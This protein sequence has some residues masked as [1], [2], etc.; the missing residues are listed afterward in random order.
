VWSGNRDTTGI[1]S[2][3]DYLTIRYSETNTCY[4]F[5]QGIF[6]NLIINGVIQWAG[7][8]PPYLA[9]L[10]YDC[11]VISFI[12]GN[13]AST[14]LHHTS[15]YEWFPYGT[16]RNRWK[17]RF[18]LRARAVRSR[19]VWPQAALISLQSTGALGKRPRRKLLIVPK[20]PLCQMWNVA[21]NTFVFF[22]FSSWAWA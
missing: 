14:V 13:W 17:V 19:A 1:R 8:N 9:Y 5:L 15:I 2:C 20:W 18:I 22:S 10:K 21:L 6:H 4:S 3:T 7:I 11:P 16:R 12:M